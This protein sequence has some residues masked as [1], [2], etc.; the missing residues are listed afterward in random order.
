[1]EKQN[2]FEQG[3]IRKTYI[4]L[5][6]PVTLSMVLSVVYNVADTYF[7]ASTQDTNLVAAVSLCAPVFMLL[8]VGQ[9]AVK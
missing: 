5:A 9:Q 7:I 1:M 8:M 2:L 4:T 6:L 3:S